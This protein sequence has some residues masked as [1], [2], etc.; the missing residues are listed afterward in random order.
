[1]SKV[2]VVI[3]VYNVEKYLG[4]CLD[5]VLRQTLKDLEVICV[6]DGS[7][8]GSPAILAEYARKDP[9]IKVVTRANGGLSAARNT[10][11]DAATGK[12]IYFLDSDDWIVDDAMEKC[13]VVCER[14]GLDQLVFGCEVHVSADDGRAIDMDMARRKAAYYRIDETLCGKVLDGAALLSELHSRRRFFAS[15]PLRFMRLDAIRTAKLRFPEGLLHEDEYFTP[16]SLLASQ[17]TEVVCDRLYRRRLRMD[18]IETARSADGGDEARHLAHLVAVMSLLGV[19]LDAAAAGKARRGAA[20]AVKK[21][22]LRSGVR[23]SLARRGVLSAA[24]RMAEGLLGEEECRGFARLCWRLRLAAFLERAR[25]RF[26]R[27]A[28]Y[29]AGGKDRSCVGGKGGG[30]GS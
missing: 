19:R 26:V 21:Y 12:Y 18:S 15:V 1:M 23:C 9:R 5:S 8:D 29:A 10:G 3:P 16:L 28:W 7:M 11:M 14:D 6:D 2:S 4:E 30:N 27:L 20:D 25:R 13:L 17:R 22:L 24:L